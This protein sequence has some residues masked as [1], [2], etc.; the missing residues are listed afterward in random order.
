MNDALA[1]FRESIKTFPSPQRIDYIKKLEAAQ[2]IAQK[3]T[4]EGIAFQKQGKYPEATAK[5]KESL[6]HWPNP[7]LEKQITVLEDDAK[8]KAEAQLAQAKQDA[9]KKD[10]A[11][12]A[13]ALWQEGTTLYN[14][15][16]MN[17][18]L[19]KFRESVK[20]FPSP[21]RID[22]IKKLE[23]AQSIAQKLTDEGIAFQKQGKSPEAAVKYKES[24]KHWPNPDLEKYIIA[25]EDD[26]KKKAEAQLAQ[27][28]QD[29]QK[30]DQVAADALWQEGTTLFTQKR[31]ND[32][33]AKFRES[34]KTFPSPQRIDYIKRLEAAQ[35]IA[36]KL[37][38]E[39][40]KPQ[41]QNSMPEVISKFT[42]IPGGP[43]VSNTW[44]K[45]NGVTTWVFYPNGQVESPGDWQG[46]WNLTAQGYRVSL[47]KSGVSDVFYVVFSGDI[48]RFTAYKGDKEYRTGVRIAAKG[49]SS[50]P[51]VKY[52]SVW[53]VTEAVGSVNIWKRRENSDQFD[54][55][56][57]NGTPAWKS[58]V[59]INGNQVTMTR[60]ELGNYTGTISAD[61]CSASGTATWYSPGTRWTAVI[62]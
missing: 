50:P 54:V 40:T 24:L 18:A 41:Q 39:G 6:N 20:T 57:P 26:A 19:A 11:T 8:K 23:A 55:F 56:S 7:D 3:L 60:P 25:L 27:A 34:V 31:I 53:R 9:Q 48:Q 21:Q 62:E 29:A 59:T 35:S 28:K 47:T 61:G 37:T 58:T 12:G 14:Q 1:R 46:N 43:E 15:K 33:L 22:Y 49:A 42:P 10:Q 51:Q 52:G 5:Y 4:D 17:D 45:V 32:A 13:D 30:K 2:S 38:D 16:R 36:Q 44:W